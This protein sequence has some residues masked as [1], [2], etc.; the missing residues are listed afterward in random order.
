M[1][2]W[3]KWEEERENRQ[4]ETKREMWKKFEFNIK[5]NNALLCF[6]VK[7]WP[8]NL[9]EFL[10]VRV[11]SAVGG[12]S[13]S[14][15]L[16]T[17]SQFATDRQGWRQ[18]NYDIIIPSIFWISVQYYT[19]YLSMSVEVNL[20]WHPFHD[21]YSISSSV[22]RQLRPILINLKSIQRE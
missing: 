6:C 8:L 9:V 15:K 3:R 13:H 7:C 11:M 10:A 20:R 1:E 21:R 17:F 14:Q 12:P 5:W 2:V 18:A 19:V 4:K 16:P 22:I